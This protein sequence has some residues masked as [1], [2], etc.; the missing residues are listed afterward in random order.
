MNKTL[1]AVLGGFVGTSAMSVILAIAE[2]EARYALGVFDAIARFVRVPGNPV[3]GF[4]IYALVGTAVWPL[5]FLSL[6]R[7]VPLELDPA[8]AG[9]FMGVVLWL[10]FAV[11]GRGDSSGVALVIYVVF[12]LAAHLVYGFSMGAVYGQLSN[13]V[14]LRDDAVSDLP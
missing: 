6:E 2:V 10:A 4:V 1:S 13:H 9:M 8:V 5:L 12:T 3:L 14:S 7:Y 11:V